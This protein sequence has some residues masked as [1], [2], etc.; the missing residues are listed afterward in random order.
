M[1]R[2][3]IIEDDQEIRELIQRL[4]ERAGYDTIMAEDGVEGM[5]AF[6]SGS[7]DIVITD[8][9]MPRMEGIETIKEIRTINATIKILAMSGG[10][11][12]APAIQLKKARGAGAT[13]TLAK[14]FK[15]DELINAVSRLV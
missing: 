1:T 11:P 3:L 12:G 6:R 13:E 4:L 7:P 10:G 9:L 5:E 14:P 15:P 2:I 8:L